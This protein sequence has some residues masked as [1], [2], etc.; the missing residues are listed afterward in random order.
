MD[1][2][3]EAVLFQIGI[4]FQMIFTP[5]TISKEALVAPMNILYLTSPLDI[6]LSV[7]PNPAT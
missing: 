1:T 2:P 5:T 4:W 3:L 7:A 6:A